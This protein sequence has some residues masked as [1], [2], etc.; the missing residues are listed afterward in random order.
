MKYQR[1]IADGWLLLI[2]LAVVTGGLWYAYNKIDSRAYQRGKQEVTIEF[3]KFKAGVEKIAAE[4]KLAAAKTEAA[5]KAE[6]ELADAKYKMVES[7]LH[8]ARADNKRLR[9]E[10][11]STGYLPPA[12]AGARNPQSA[13]VNRAKFERAMEYIDEEGARIA[14][15]GDRERAGLNNAKIWAQ[16]EN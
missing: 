5:E 6:K 15:A 7:D 16:G 4:S 1:G 13:T 3:D 9:D 10:R 8:R 11:A 12:K 14:E 2:A